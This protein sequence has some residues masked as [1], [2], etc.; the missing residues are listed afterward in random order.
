MKRVCV[1]C[2]EPIV[3]GPDWP[4]PWSDVFIRFKV[5][6][7]RREPRYGPTLYSRPELRAWIA[8]DLA[9]GDLREVDR[10]GAVEARLDR[11]GIVVSREPGKLG[12]PDVFTT[13]DA[14][15][16]SEANRMLAIL[17]REM[18]YGACK[19]AWRRLPREFVIMPSPTLTPPPAVSP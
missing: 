17:M 5:R 13:A 1:E 6:P 2:D 7:G 16:R 18:G 11:E 15:T 19:F 10:L 9:Y 14:I 4:Q 3:V 12:I 8:H